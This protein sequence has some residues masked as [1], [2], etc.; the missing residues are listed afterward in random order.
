MD[1][2]VL[3]RAGA[4]SAAR[5]LHWSSE[6]D[7]KV[8]EHCAPRWSLLARI[9][10]LL[11]VRPSNIKRT[12]TSRGDLIADISPYTRCYTLMVLL[13]LIGYKGLHETVRYDLQYIWN[14]CQGELKLIYVLINLMKCKLL[15]KILHNFGRPTFEK[16]QRTIRIEITL[17]TNFCIRPIKNIN[18]WVVYRCLALF[19]RAVLP[20]I[21]YRSLKLYIIF[22]ISLFFSDGLNLL[23]NFLIT[24][25]TIGQAVRRGWERGG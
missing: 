12:V 18:L 11:I 1:R 9:Y 17:T 4:R 6:C 20:A 5:P 8:Y 2:H 25:E 15:K 24:S 13:K 21:Y 7:P 16:Y 10:S 3:G 23:H 14:Y 19:R 22:Y